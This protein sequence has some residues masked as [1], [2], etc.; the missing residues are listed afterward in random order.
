MTQHS[1]P[2]P[3]MRSSAGMNLNDSVFERLLRERIIVLGSQ[4]EE[5]IANQ[6]TAQ[7]LLLAAEDPEKD[8]TLYI[9]S[10]GGSVTAGMAIF[11]T[12]QLIEPDVATTAMGL[13]AS[14]GQFLLSAGAPGKRSILP[15]A[16]VLMHQPSAGVGGT[17]ADIA[18][19][20]DMLT[21]TKHEMAELIAEHTGQPVDRIIADSDRD[22]WFT[23][24][25]AL[26]YGF[27]DKVITR[28]TRVSNA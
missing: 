19:Q 16:R 15:H 18:I 8:I 2:T 13:A 25:E 28:P 6:I 24:A 26:E 5:G 1:F 4:V 12:M 7:L 23:A 11:D 20:A 3:E 10:P 21:R 22:R 9:N 17:A 14:M 27:V